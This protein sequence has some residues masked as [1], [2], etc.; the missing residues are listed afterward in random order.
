MIGRYGIAIIGLSRL[1]AWSAPAH[2]PP[3]P[4]DV[5]S[6]LETF[7]IWRFFSFDESDSPLEAFTVARSV[8]QFRP[9]LV[10]LHFSP[11]WLCTE[12]VVGFNIHCPAVT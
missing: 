6:Q 4:G 8:A 11:T 7:I 9:L 5:P 12:S 3:N 2:I 1:L 10:F